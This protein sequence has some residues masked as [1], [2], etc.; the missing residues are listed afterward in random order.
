M[1]I[2][3]LGWG[4]L[5]WDPNGLPIEHTN[6]VEGAWSPDGPHLPVEFARHSS[7]SRIYAFVD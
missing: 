5:V 3:V 4:S 1:S 7:G 6:P 2:I